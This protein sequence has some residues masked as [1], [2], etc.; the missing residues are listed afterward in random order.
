M[1]N[2]GGKAVARIGKRSSELAEQMMTL[3]EQGETAEAGRRDA[4]RKHVSGLELT[5]ESQ[6][7]FC[8]LVGMQ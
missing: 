7:K 1:W 8:Y 3:G 5:G 4:Y 2:N 6:G